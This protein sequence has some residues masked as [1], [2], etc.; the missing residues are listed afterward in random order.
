MECPHPFCHCEPIPDKRLD[1]ID[2]DLGKLSTQVKEVSDQLEECCVN[3]SGEI[4]ELKK[5]VADSKE[6]L[7]IA[8]SD[9]GVPTASDDTFA[10]MVTNISNIPTGSEWTLVANWDFTQS[11]TDTISNLTCDL[12]NYT[13]QESTGIRFTTN[14]TSRCRIPYSNTSYPNANVMP[15]NG[16]AIEFDVVEEQ[17]TN[18]GRT[19]LM[20][21][22]NQ[23]NCLMHYNV[24]AP[25][26]VTR[27][28]FRFDNQGVDNNVYDSSLTGKT[29]RVEIFSNNAS[30]W[31]TYYFYVDG[32]FL[33]SVT[34]PYS[35]SPNSSWICLGP[36]SSGGSYRGM[37]N[38]I[39]SGMRIYIIPHS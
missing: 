9:K 25:A 3:M 37:N 28:V 23:G 39:V 17:F 18:T 20:A 10:T 29:V 32:E 26:G 19:T 35:Y 7:A 22:G 34:S 33:T 4:E 36:Y 1:L 12:G 5:S 38:G 21:F 6:S 14:T 16:M 2:N 8:I 27:W 15:R 13:Y 31:L 11:L 30:N 24:N